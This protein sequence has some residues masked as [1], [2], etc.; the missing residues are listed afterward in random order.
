MWANIPS[1]SCNYDWPRHTV[2]HR[3]HASPDWS[4]DHAFSGKADVN[5]LPRRAKFVCFH[6]AIGCRL[7]AQGTLRSSLRIE[8]F[9]LRCA[10]SDERHDK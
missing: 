6:R 10:Q 5:R 8:I 2:R 4:I 7:G 9:F 3:D 1:G